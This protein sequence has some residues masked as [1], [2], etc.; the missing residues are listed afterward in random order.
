MNLFDSLFSAKTNQ[1]KQ[2]SLVSLFPVANEQTS[3]RFYAF[4]I[5]TY[6]L[7]FWKNLIWRGQLTVIFV[8]SSKVAQN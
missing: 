2:A 4:R 6:K 7:V 8:S 3:Q 1:Y 5:S